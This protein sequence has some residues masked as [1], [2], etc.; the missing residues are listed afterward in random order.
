MLWQRSCRR[1]PYDYLEFSLTKEEW[2]RKKLR[3]KRLQMR[4]MTVLKNRQG[5]LEITIII[6]SL[7]GICV[8][9]KDIEQVVG[10]ALGKRIRAGRNSK[11]VIGDEYVTLNFLEDTNFQVL[12][13]A[14][15]SA[16]GK[17]GI[18]GDN[19]GFTNLSCGQVLMT[20]S[21]GM[22]YGKYAYT[23]SET[24]VELLEELL[25][26]GFKNEV[27]LKL[28]NLVMMINSDSND[29]ATADMGILD[30]YT[31]ICQ[32]VKM[33][34]APT[35]IKRGSWVEVIKSTSLP[36]G[37]LKQVDYEQTTKK[38]YDGDMIIMVSDGMIDG[39]RMNDKEQELSEMIRGIKTNN[40]KE[41]A[42]ELLRK[43]EKEK[44]NDVDDDRT[45][46]HGFFP[47]LRKLV[48]LF[49]CNGNVRTF[50]FMYDALF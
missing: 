4:R 3:S 32:F 31:G 10:E 47:R 23:E 42:N 33:G 9:T 14:A 13:G 38:I 41:F 1:C 20:L 24:V 15:K 29:T 25:E 46:L 36:M 44:L 2:I 39:L 30:L 12:C 37:V 21:D 17:N 43:V 16:R 40:P 34:A 28:V 45:V 49:L 19:F 35:F 22:G 11:I 26:S 5:R 6:K 7:K 27:A 48:F 8:S 50:R 18:S